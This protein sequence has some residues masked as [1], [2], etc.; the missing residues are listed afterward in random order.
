MANLHIVGAEGIGT[1]I[2][3]VMVDDCPTLR[4]LCTMAVELSCLPSIKDRIA[5]M[6]ML[7]LEAITIRR[8]VK[9][10]RLES[11]L[12]LRRRHNGDR[13]VR[14]QTTQLNPLSYA[15]VRRDGCDRHL[16]ALLFLLLRRSG[17]IAKACGKGLHSGG[18]TWIAAM[19]SRGGFVVVDAFSVA[20]VRANA[21][22]FNPTD[23]SGKYRD[24]DV[25]WVW[26]N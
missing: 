14:V 6:E 25:T 22:A 19:D 5:T 17:V 4:R 1:N 10:S 21:S 2:C 7:T 11:R 18:Y 26:D 23:P 20:L 8:I 12:A 24:P 15:L 3:G 9:E 13:S 16:H